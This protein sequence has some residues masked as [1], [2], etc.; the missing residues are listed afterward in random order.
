MKCALGS[1]LQQAELSDAK[2]RNEHT[3]KQTHT[4][5]A[6]YYTERCLS[7]SE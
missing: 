4:W 2:G 5:L 3:N 1:L 6:A 7:E